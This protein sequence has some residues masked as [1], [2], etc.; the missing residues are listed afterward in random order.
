MDIR[1]KPV[2]N[3]THK[4]DRFKTLT[5]PYLFF[6]L[7]IDKNNIWLNFAKSA[8]TPLRENEDKLC[9]QNS[10]KTAEPI[11]FGTTR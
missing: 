10:S 9:V 2:R 1:Q 5:R 8:H 3:N 4:L 7:E 6:T 11:S